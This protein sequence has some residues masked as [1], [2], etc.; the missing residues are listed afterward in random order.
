MTKLY[1]VPR[2]TW[3]EF[4]GHKLFFHHIDGMYSLCED[5]DKTIVHLA[6]WADVE[7]LEDDHESK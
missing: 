4:K 3:I 2:N 7:I 5:K 6:A 1:D